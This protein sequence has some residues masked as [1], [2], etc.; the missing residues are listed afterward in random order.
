MNTTL[1]IDGNWLLMSRLFI[2]K[3]YFNKEN[4]EEDKL[5]GTAQLKDLICQSINI[6]INR[7]SGVIDNIILVKDGGSWRKEIEKPNFLQEKYKGN[8]E[9]SVEYDWSYIFK[10]LD[11]VIDRAAEIG[12]TACKAHNIEGDDW[13]Y[14]WSKTLNKKGINCI[15][16]SSDADLKQLIQVDSGAFTVWFNESG[17]GGMPGL[18]VHKD[19]DDSKKDVID[20]FMDSY[21]SNKNLD[22]LCT[23]VST[24]TYINPDEIVENKII[25]G[26]TSDNIKSIIRIKKNNK[27]YNVSENEWKKQKEKLNISSLKDFFDRKDVICEVLSKLKKYDGCNKEQVKEMFDYNKKLVWLNEKIIPKK[28]ID[29]MASSEYKKFDLSYIR[30]NYKVLSNTKE[31]EKK[32]EDIFDNIDITADMP[33]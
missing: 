20:L 24:V 3:D 28:I 5:N 2:V 22:E 29:I 16:W 1:L 17:R 23:R 13:I 14:Y 9:K 10:A 4:T 21:K 32:I 18:F 6:I 33:F 12:I 15:I 25:C 26:D 11:E 31:E 30:N 7:F 8:R 27:T 19:L